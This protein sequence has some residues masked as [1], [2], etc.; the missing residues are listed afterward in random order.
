MKKLKIQKL[1]NSKT[2]KF[3]KSEREADGREGG[4]DSR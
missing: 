4:G 2:Q 3:K 1:K